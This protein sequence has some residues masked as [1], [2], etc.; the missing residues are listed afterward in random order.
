MLAR[1]YM[2]IAQ[3]KQN[4]AT[5]WAIRKKWDSSEIIDFN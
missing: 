4:W 2:Q 5:V 3:V 1:L